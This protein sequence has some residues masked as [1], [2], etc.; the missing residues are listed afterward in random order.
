MDPRYL[1]GHG[2]GEDGRYYYEPKLI[3]VTNDANALV[4]GQKTKNK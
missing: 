4:C 1:Q 2:G 3:P